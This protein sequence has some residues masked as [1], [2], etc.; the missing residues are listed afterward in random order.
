MEKIK[1][2]K[3]IDCTP[4]WESLVP[5]FISVLEDDSATDE[6]KKIIK[7]EIRHMAQV[8]DMHVTHV[9]S[10]K[11]DS[12]NLMERIVDI[13]RPKFCGDTSIVINAKLK[14]IGMKG[15]DAEM[16]GLTGRTTHP[17][18]LGYSTKGM[19][20]I[21]LDPGQRQVT[22]DDRAN[23]EAKHIRFIE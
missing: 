13:A 4:T 5:W 10:R 22:T 20:G 23:V 1:E 3:T 12:D 21:Y 9:K 8:A 11:I 16:N 19:V 7:Q 18:P 2:K 6:S 15:D 17:F 14:I